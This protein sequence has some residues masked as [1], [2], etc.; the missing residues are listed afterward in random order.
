MSDQTVALTATYIAWAEPPYVTIEFGD[1]EI[2]R[3]DPATYDVKPSDY[4][5]GDDSSYLDSENKRIAEETAAAYVRRMFALAETSAF[6]AEK[7]KP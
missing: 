6:R 1:T 2:A 4:G 5:H 7:E 3:L